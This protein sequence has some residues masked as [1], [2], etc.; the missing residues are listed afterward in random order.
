MIGPLEIIILYV[1]YYTARYN[2]LQQLQLSITNEAHSNE[3]RKEKRKV[4]RSQY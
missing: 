1:G 2:H 4:Q 3:K